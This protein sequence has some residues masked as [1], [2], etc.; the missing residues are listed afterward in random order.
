MAPG[1]VGVAVDQALHAVAL[2]RLAH[3]AVVHVHDLRGLGLHHFLALL[4]HAADRLAALGEGLARNAC[5]QAAER[6]V[7]RQAW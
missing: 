3:R 7:R 6:A 2:H 4:A 1:A 5:C